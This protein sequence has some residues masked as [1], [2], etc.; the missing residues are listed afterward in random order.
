MSFFVYKFQNHVIAAGLG[1]DF[2]KPVAAGGDAVARDSSVPSR[3][4]W[5][6][7]LLRIEPSQSRPEFLTTSFC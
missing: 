7:K 2:F 6:S 3:P 4:R 1:R 5:V